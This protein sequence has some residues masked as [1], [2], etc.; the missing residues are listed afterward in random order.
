MQIKIALCTFNVEVGVTYRQ[1]F[2][3]I[4]NIERG[5]GGGGGLLDYVN[6]CK[7]SSVPTLLPEL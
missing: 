5:G 3:S 6:A 4:L 7:C 2:D 1:H